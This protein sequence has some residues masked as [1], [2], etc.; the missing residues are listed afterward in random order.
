MHKT[1]LMVESTLLQIFHN[2]VMVTTFPFSQH[3]SITFLIASTNCTMYQSSRDINSQSLRC[4]VE[5]EIH[6]LQ[7]SPMVDEECNNPET[8]KQ[9]TDLGQIYGGL[10]AQQLPY[11]NYY[12]NYGAHN[13]FQDYTD[14]NYVNFEINS[15]PTYTPGPTSEDSNAECEYGR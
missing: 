6:C 14:W 3:I 8:D 10:S 2:A 12:N 15:V 5:E 7:G 11:A 9:T 13:S 1:K 4:S